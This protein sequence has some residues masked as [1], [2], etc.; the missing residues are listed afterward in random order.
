MKIRVLTVGKIENRNLRE[1]SELYLKRIAHYV[2]IRMDSVRSSK[3]NASAGQ[4]KRD[5]ASRLLK[6][7]SDDEFLVVLDSSGKE[8]TSEAFAHFIE[9][10]ALQSTPRITFLIGGPL[11]LDESVR[12]KAR[13][14]LSLSKMTLPHELAVVVLLEQIYR[15]MTI[16]RG[17]KYHK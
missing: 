13:Q 15:A 11:G 17:E 10:H 3:M 12:A 4:I 7:L 1:L 16:W 2:P 6:K 8:M 5:E 9:Q 14:K